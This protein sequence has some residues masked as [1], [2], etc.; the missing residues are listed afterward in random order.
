[1]RSNPSQFANTVGRGR[2]CRGWT[3]SVSPGSTS[4]RICCAGGTTLI[5]RRLFTSRSSRL[6]RTTRK[7]TGRSFCVA[8][9]SNMLRIRQAISA[10]R[11]STACDSARSWRMRT[12]CPRSGM[13]MTSRN[14]S[15]LP[16]LKQSKPFRRAI[17]RSPS[18][19]SRSTCLSAIR[20]PMTTANAPWTLCWQ[21]TSIT[22]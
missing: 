19:K 17:W 11:R 7:H 4:V 6:R 10:C 12:I 5:R 13:L 2:R 9:E 20:K 18:V 21:M 16:R 1:M 14:L 3:V 8:T 22:S 15:I